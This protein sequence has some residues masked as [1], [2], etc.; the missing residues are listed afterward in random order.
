MYLLVLVKVF[1]GT[2]FIGILFII[3]VPCREMLEFACGIH[4]R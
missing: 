2:N 3:T 4:R 1:W